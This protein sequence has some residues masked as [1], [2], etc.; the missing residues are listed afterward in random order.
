MSDPLKMSPKVTGSENPGH[1]V[2]SVPPSQLSCRAPHLYGSPVVPPLST[3]DGPHAWIGRQ[4][5]HASVLQATGAQGH[6]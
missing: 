5:P 2:L 4:G 3:A 6:F 1:R